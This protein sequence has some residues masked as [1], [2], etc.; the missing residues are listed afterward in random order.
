MPRVGKLS[1]YKERFIGALQVNGEVVSPDP[2][3]TR[4][5]FSGITTASVHRKASAP[6]HASV[7]QR[8]T[9]VSAAT[10]PSKKM[11]HSYAAWQVLAVPV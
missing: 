2:H 9:Q 7:D 5:S 3:R 4:F 10:G 8:V 6:Q 11:A 1:N